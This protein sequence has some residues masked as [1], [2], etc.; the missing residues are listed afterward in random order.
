[1]SEQQQQGTTP[2]E[3][4][5]QQTPPV[6]GGQQ[7]Q[8]TPPATPPV[9]TPPAPAPEDTQAKFLKELGFEKLEDLQSSLQKLQQIEDKDKTETQ[10]L[11][12]QAQKDSK[13]L[14]EYE[15]QVF[16]LSAEKAA[17]AANANPDNVG[18]IITLA[19]SHTNKETDITKAISIVLEKYP[20]FLKEGAQQQGQNSGKPQFAQQQ[21]GAQQSEQDKWNAAFKSM[22]AKN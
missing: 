11:A 3:E 12:D 13:K 5:Q 16:Q 10:K 6:D 4:Q 17:L 1:M 15:E 8:T 22:F 21:Q 19:K 9:V 20:H 18:D 14:K 2:P 7:Q